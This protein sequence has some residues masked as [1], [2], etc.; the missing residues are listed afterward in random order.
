MQVQALKVELRD[1]E[2]SSGPTTPGP[3]PP[4]GLGEELEELEMRT[5]QN[6]AELMHTGHWEE[7]LQAELALEEGWCFAEGR[8]FIFNYLRLKSVT[9][10]T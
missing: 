10:L 9:Y 6:E 5:R 3:A 8:S 1:C 2:R 7:Q 4:P